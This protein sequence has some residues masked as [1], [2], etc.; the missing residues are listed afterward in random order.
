MSYIDEMATPIGTLHILVSDKAVL[1]IYFQGEKIERSAVCTPKNKLILRAKKELTEYFSGKRKKFT[2]PYKL[3]G[4]PFQKNAWKVLT[5]IS[6]GTTIDYSEEAAQV[7]NGGA[8]RAIGSANGKNPIPI[9]IPCH[10]VVPKDGGFGGYS[11]GVKR[12]K[13]LLALEGVQTKK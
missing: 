5:K 7:G 3:S 2:I 10:R 13:Y 11:G 12:K 6:Y 1:R 9:I 8:V 4:T